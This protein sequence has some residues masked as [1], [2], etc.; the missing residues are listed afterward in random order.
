MYLTEEG[1]I[2]AGAPCPFSDF[3][4]KVEDACKKEAF[5]PYR[6]TIAEKLNAKMEKD[7]DNRFM[8]IFMDRA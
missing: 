6:C 3:C 8:K 1:L 4:D 5:Y 2:P 7:F